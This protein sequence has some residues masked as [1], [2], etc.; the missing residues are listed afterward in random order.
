MNRDGTV[1]NSVANE[2]LKDY[3]DF[4]YNQALN[5]EHEEASIRSRAYDA[6]IEAE[7]DQI[8]EFVTDRRTKALPAAI[9]TFNKIQGRKLPSYNTDIKLNLIKNPDTPSKE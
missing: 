4:V 2:V 3:K 6:A 7:R 8:L 9:E 1:K 5:D